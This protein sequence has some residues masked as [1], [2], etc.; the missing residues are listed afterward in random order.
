MPRY[1]FNVMNDVKTQDFDGVE[2][3]DLDAARGEAQRDIEEIKETHFESIGNDWTAWSIE[4]CDRDGLL[5][6]VVP[7]KSN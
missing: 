4:I 6:L 2:L 3:P 1:F 5:L 7:F